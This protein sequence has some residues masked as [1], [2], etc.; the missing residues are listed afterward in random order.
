MLTT[1]LCVG[2]ASAQSNRHNKIGNDRF[3]IKLQP[4]M[5][6]YLMASS[7]LKEINP[8]GPVGINFGIEFPSTRQRPW[9]QYLNDP[10]VGLGIS[11][12][13]FGAKTMGKGVAMYPYIMIN[14][15]RS[16]HFHL[17][18]KLGS[19]LL[20]LNEHYYTTLDEPTPN[21]TFSTTINAYLTGGLNFE[22][23][24]TRNFAIN[25]TG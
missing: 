17:K 9:Q 3:A 5:G 11:Y 2:A 16:E 24:I 23:P 10:T 7:N 20:A 21:K 15:V 12:I 6:G 25:I 1:L 14:G 19:G 13:D 18:V 8:N 22:F 4:F